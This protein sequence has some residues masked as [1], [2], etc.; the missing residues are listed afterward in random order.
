[1]D[2]P[3]SSKGRFGSKHFDEIKSEET[4]K[5]GLEQLCSSSDKDMNA[6]CLNIE[7]TNRRVAWRLPKVSPSSVF[8][9]VSPFHFKA[10]R[11]IKIKE[12]S[13][14]TKLNLNAMMTIPFLESKHIQAA[15]KSGYGFVHL[16]MVR[17]G[18]NAVHRTGRKT[19]VFSALLDNRWTTFTQAVIGG[20]E[21]VL[22][23]GPVQ[24]DVHPNFS[25]SL[26]DPHIL[27]C[28][29]LGVKTQGYENFLSEA[30]YLTISYITCVRFY[31]TTIPAVLRSPAN[32]SGVVTLIQYDSAC[33]P[34]APVSVSTRDLSPP[35][36]WVINW[37]KTHQKPVALAQPIIQEIDNKVIIRFPRVQP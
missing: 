37:K 2:S 25:V 22:S 10:R 5:S 17:I 28:L 6:A 18:I 24:Y 36:D 8:S 20:I 30:K 19:F 27:K 9:G 26:K 12:K 14:K 23:D 13:I 7:E 1:M 4:L 35:D 21:A 33:N 31:K 32:N 34:V 3:S 15:I 11:Q 16:G 29:T